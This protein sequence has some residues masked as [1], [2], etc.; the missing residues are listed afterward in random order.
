MSTAVDTATPIKRLDLADKCSAQ[1]GGQAV[2]C[3]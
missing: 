1:A 3:L 2:Y